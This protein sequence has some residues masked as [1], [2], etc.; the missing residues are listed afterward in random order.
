MIGKG[1]PK[2]GGLKYKTGTNMKNFPNVLKAKRTINWSPKITLLNGLKRTI[3]LSMKK[4]PLVSII[5]NCLN[6]EKYLSNAID[7]VIKQT[8]K[9]LS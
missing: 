8:Y 6:G 9:N 4:Q 3:K 5:M 7:S 2:F 1:K